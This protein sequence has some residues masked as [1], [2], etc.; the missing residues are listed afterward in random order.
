MI[1]SAYLRSAN[2]EAK[3]MFS[4]VSVSHSVHG[5]A[6]GRGPNTLSPLGLENLEKWD[7]TFQS[8]I[9]TRLEKSG[10]ITQNTG[11]LIAKKQKGKICK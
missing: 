7:G 10:I 1:F 6:G 2:G 11:K 8:G 3:V 5:G 9:F 4:V